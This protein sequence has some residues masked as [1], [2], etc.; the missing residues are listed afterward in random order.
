M[1]TITSIKPSSRDPLRCI[2][3]VGREVVARLSLDAVERVGLEVGVVGEAAGKTDMVGEARR[4]A[5]KKL[6]S[7]GL[8]RCD[9]VARKRRLWGA[10]ARRGFDF[11]TIEAAM[12]GLDEPE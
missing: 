10:L 11:D 4:L 12:K 6:R 1:N 9:P 5:E 7:A 3:K 8:Q 2:V